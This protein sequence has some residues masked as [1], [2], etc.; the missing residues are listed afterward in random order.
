MATRW[1]D[2]V[3]GSVGRVFSGGITALRAQAEGEFRA[4]FIALL[5]EVTTRGVAATGDLGP[6]IFALV[7]PP[8][9]ALRA[10]VEDEPHRAI[11]DALNRL[12]QRRG[13]VASVT[14]SALREAA[15]AFSPDYRRW[16]ARFLSLLESD[17]GIIFFV[18][19]SAIAREIER[20]ASRFRLRAD[21]DPEESCVLVSDGVYERALALDSAVAEALWTMRGPVVVAAER[22]TRL[23]AEF[24]E[25][26]EMAEAL[27]RRFPGLT[28]TPQD[29]AWQASVGP[30][31]GRV[32]YRELVRQ[33]R[34]AELDPD[35]LLTRTRLSDLFDD[36]S[37]VHR[38]I[39]APSFISAYP[40]TL[41]RSWGG[42]IEALA[43]DGQDGTRYIRR[44][45]DDPR[46]RYAH[47]SL[48]ATMARS[49]HHFTG[50]MFRAEVGSR[51]AICIAGAQAVSLAAEP[52]LVSGVLEAVGS[53]RHRVRLCSTFEHG[54]IIA[55]HDLVEEAIEVLGASLRL[56]AVDL[57]E[58]AGDALRLELSMELDDHSSG[59]CELREVP[60]T[61]FELRERADQ[62]E[63]SGPPGRNAYFRGL[64]FEILGLPERALEHFTRALRYDRDDGELNLLLG[65]T[66]N[67]T[68]EFD[69]AT[70]FLERAVRA[71]PEDADASNSLGVAYQSMGASQ[72]ALRAFERAAALSPEDPTILV[73]LGRAYFDT[74]RLESARDMLTRALERAPALFEAHASLAMLH[75]RNGDRDDALEHA[76]VA[77]AERPEDETMRELVA[78]L[79]SDPGEPS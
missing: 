63:R 60:G 68:G 69:R 78:L 20:A 28:L 4:A 14:W 74:D 41:Y 6:G 26:D 7:L 35:A 70:A 34:R 76:R 43:R 19:P 31:S 25:Y 44:F 32:S 36:G 9:D 11:D 30:V 38:K 52:A 37:C 8:P 73:N 77:L 64:C 23:P 27:L 58:D 22:V 66:L 40:D 67:D 56:L 24:L 45:D 47:L 49:L 29:G 12:T 72:E 55:D 53:P 48:M 10:P 18:D 5:E 54:L 75:F 42:C 3:R 46:G 1:L 21:Y 59:C 57:L 39:K 62:A 65:R 51:Q 50:H 71:L 2:R 61:Y 13:N 16:G 79:V 33:Q 15:P 17:V